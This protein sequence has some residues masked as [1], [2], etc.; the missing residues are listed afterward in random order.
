ML[1]CLDKITILKKQVELNYEYVA[2][3]KYQTEKAQ[4]SQAIQNKLQQILKERANTQNAAT[5]NTKTQQ[6]LSN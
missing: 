2:Q 1:R 3:Q 5:V 4:Y 6:T